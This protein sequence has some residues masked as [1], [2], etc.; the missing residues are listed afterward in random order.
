M[1]QSFDAQVLLIKISDTRVAATTY[2][3]WCSVSGAIVDDYLLPFRVRLP[4]HTFNA[5]A[6]E[7][8]VV[9][10]RRNYAN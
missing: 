1:G 9:I 5:R 8:F 6:D 2:D 10:S 7:F 3:L 4:K